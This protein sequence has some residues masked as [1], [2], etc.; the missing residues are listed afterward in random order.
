MARGLLADPEWVNKVRDGREHEVRKCITCNQCIDRVLK[1]LPIRCAINPTAGRES[2]FGETPVRTREPKKVVVVGAGPGGMEAARVAGA[3]GHS[4]TLFE[5]TGELGGGQLK[6]AAAA[7]FK[8]E[9]FGIV[10]YY[11]SQFARLDNVRIRL[12][13]EV[14]I[15]DLKAEQPDIVILATG[16]TALVPAIEGVD[17][18]N[19]L[20]NHDLLARRGELHGQVVIA[21]GGCAGAGTADL[22]SE[23]GLDV[24]VLEMLE[25]CALDEELITRLTLMHRFSQKWNVK[26]LTGHTVQR[27]TDAGVVAVT[28]SGEE[29]TMAAD[30]VVLAFGA[31]P[32][33]PLEAQ[34][35]EHF[36]VCHVIGDAVQPRKI[37]DAIADGFFVGQKV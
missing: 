12:N 37:K 27:I 21:G 33:N 23:Q 22:L 9:Y 8:E 26:L 7:P 36:A 31:V 14:G 17:R 6:L 3:R 19:V 15:D 16:A 30:F 34:V 29:V 32:C 35:R 10:D 20:T 28:K 24:T 1:S 4:V 18:A 13:T 25:E 5:K 11:R 2:E